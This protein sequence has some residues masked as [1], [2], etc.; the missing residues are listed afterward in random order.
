MNF[1][2]EPRAL[3]LSAMVELLTLLTAVSFL[4]SAL[5]SAFSFRVRFGLNYFQIAQPSD[6]V[7]SGFQNIAGLMLFLG[8]IGS[9]CV[10]LAPW[11]VRLR[12][13]RRLPRMGGLVPFVFGALLAPT[14]F[15]INWLSSYDAKRPV[16][17]PSVG[18][19]GLTLPIDG[20]YGAKC[21]QAPVL[22]IGSASMVIN[23]R[24]KIAVINNTQGL[25]VTR[26]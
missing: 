8:L 22:W 23:C 3:R 1:V 18:V 20:P 13:L 24:N 12:W 21:G 15:S 9:F 4:A 10:M 25:L 6:I 2:G 14:A 16:S 5:I 26:P 19:N 17:L 7:M 11:F